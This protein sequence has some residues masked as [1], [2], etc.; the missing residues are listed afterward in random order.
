MKSNIG[1][2]QGAAGVAS[3][4]KMVMALRHGA[5][6]R[7]LHADAPSPHIDW[8]SGALRLLT[9]PKTWLPRRVAPARGHRSFGVSG[10]NA[11][12]IIE[13]APDTG[14]PGGTA[15][16]LDGPVPLLLSAKSEPALH[17]Q[18]GRLADWL[19]G[20]DDVPL[21]DAGWSLT[22]GRARL[23]H[24]AVVVASDHTGAVSLLRALEA[25]TETP[26][27]TSGTVAPGSL[28]L[29]FTGQGAQRAGMGAALYARYPVF[30]AAADEV[31][32][33]LD[34]E[35]A[36]YGPA[37]RVH[38]VW[39]VMSGAPGTEGLLDET[40]WTQPAL[41]TFEV[42]LFRLLESWG[43]RPDLVL[44]HSVG[45]VAAAYAAGLFSLEDAVRV[46][47]ARGRLMQE[48]PAGGAMVAVAAPES[49]VRPLLAGREDRVAIGAVNSPSSVVLSGAG[50][51]VLA[52]AETLAGTGV[53]TRRLTVSHAFHSPL[54]EPMLD[55]F[56][57]VLDSVAWHSPR[58]RFVSSVTG[59]IVDAPTLADA[60]YWLGNVRQPVRFA[61]AVAAAHAAGAATFIEVGPG[62]VLTALGR[63]SVADDRVTFTAAHRHDRPEDVTALTAAGHLY[64]RGHAADFAPLF[65][66][67]SVTDLPTYAFQRQRYWVG[68]ATPGTAGIDGAG[69]SG[70]DHPLLSAIVQRPEGG[71]VI[72]TG[73]LSLDSHPWLADHAI[74]GTVLVPGTALVELAGRAADESGASVGELVIETPLVLP[75]TGA[76][77]LQVSVG[78]PDGTG[79]AP[80]AIHSRPA[81]ASPETAWSRHAAGA[82]SATVAPPS[83]GLTEWPPP[84]ATEADLAGFYERQHAAG[85][86]YGPVFQGLRRVWTS[87]DEVFAEVELDAGQ[88]PDA[89]RYGLHPALL[90]AVLH[91]TSFGA[92][93]GTEPGRLLLP[94]AWNGVTLHTSGA[95]NLR[96]RIAVTGADTVALRLADQTGAP[97][98]DVAALVF[99]PVAI[100]SIGSG[101][102]TPGLSKI[103]WS[104]PVELPGQTGPAAVLDPSGRDCLAVTGPRYPDPAA[105]IA[106]LTSGSAPLP[107]TVFFAP[108]DTLGQCA[109]AP[110][111][112]TRPAD[113]ARA[114]DL[115]GRTLAVLQAW[116]DEP[117][118]QGIRL[119]VITRGGAAT[120]SHDATAADPAASAVWGLVRTAQSEH[121]GRF[122]IIDVDVDDASAAVLEAVAAA[123]EPQAAIRAGIAVA[124]RAAAVT[125]APELTGGGAFGSGTV[126]DH[127]R[128]RRPR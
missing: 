32:A 75:R 57:R 100:D 103:D 29:L 54:M 41:F 1:H 84:G 112:E 9:E 34:T 27:V 45:E 98:A 81:G 53:R 90:D 111:G 25:G 22:T 66:G 105:L 117:V 43:V 60:G 91:A 85:Y 36:G 11:H 109:P 126:L 8:S 35:L 106:A 46:V 67:A 26:G 72:A 28:A 31:T 118:L 55:G 113:A 30:A 88:Y 62:G 4:I 5:V 47:A 2:T 59:E 6:P 49:V 38:G 7:T 89:A 44:G 37:D 108:A 78:E 24:R 52:V 110:D 124:P 99:R 115:V 68:N 58:L 123:G 121:P 71:G 12:V 79:S 102:V 20:A 64:A 61:D 97:V 40:G 80:L 127:R 23:D 16:A 77:H 42:A 86:E 95:V 92:V 33:L 101:Q 93:T 18:A 128:Y 114:R 87:G 50:P 96:A 56:R 13:E 74:G 73:R 104:T 70:A 116:A 69:L 15:P 21:G 76:V 125:G 39:D 19:D 17:A 82:V 94:F 10:T 63:E 51:D 83:P 14:L 122:T 65:P 3:I 48:L 107:E 119:A 120:S